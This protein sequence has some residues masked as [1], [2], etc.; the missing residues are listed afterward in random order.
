MLRLTKCLPL[1]V[2]DHNSDGS[3]GSNRTAFTVL[4]IDSVLTIDTISTD[5]S[6]EHRLCAVRESHNEHAIRVDLHQGDT[7]AV[8]AIASRRSG[9]SSRPRRPVLSGRPGRSGDRL[10]RR[11]RRYW[12]FFRLVRIGWTDWDVRIGPPA[13]G[14]TAPAIAASSRESRL[15]EFPVQEAD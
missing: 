1:L 14:A 15:S 11:C 5:N 12:D 7:P 9:R 13:R 8:Q 2:S 6:A 4:S 10:R 3:S